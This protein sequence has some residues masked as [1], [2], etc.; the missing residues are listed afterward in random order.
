MFKRRVGILLLVMVGASALLLGRAAHVQVWQHGSWDA[1]VADELSR[2]MLTATTRGRIL[3]RNGN[4][5]AKDGPEMD[6]AVDYRV[7]GVEPDEQWL[8]WRAYNRLKRDPA[9][10]KKYLDADRAKRDELWEA[11]KTALRGELADMWRILAEA[12]GTDPADI[13]DARREILSKV[14]ARR[15]FIAETRYRAALSEWEATDPPGWWRRWLLGENHDPPAADEFDETIDEELQH[16]VVLEAIPG[17][18]RVEL[19]RQLRRFE[20]ALV[21]QTTQRREY[22]FGDVAAHVIGVLGQVSRT[23]LDADPEPGERRRRYFQNDLIGKGGLEQIAERRLRGTRGV[24]E[25]EMGDGAWELADQTPGLPGDDVRT[26]LDIAFTRDIQRAF[27]NVTAPLLTEDADGRTGYHT[28][29]PMPGGA[30][31]IDVDS[32]ELLALV[33]YPSYDL[34]DYDAD[35][36]LLVRDPVNL[37]LYNRAT[38]F[39]ATPGSTMK[40][41]TGIAGV[42]EGTTDVGE[43]ITC[44]GYLHIDGQRKTFG[45]CWIMKTYGVTHQENR[46]NPPGVDFSA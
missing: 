24:I 23:D 42:L 25:R 35:Y 28:R 9:L 26:T 3:D 31:V 21:L 46:H 41:L 20:G 8:K 27:E 44:D 34:N 15:T 33:S 40:P 19:A 14:H 38:Q 13:D 11:E 6:A 22:P 29:Q 39:A 12:T 7:L 32:A 43:R 37:P 16:H 1:F 18:A 2:S 17:A 10:W 45:R 36:E 4:V 30:V 5:L